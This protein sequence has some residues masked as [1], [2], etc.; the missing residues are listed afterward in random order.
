MSSITSGEKT[1]WAAAF[2]AAYAEH[3]SIDYALGIAYKAVLDIRSVLGATGRSGMTETQ[4]AIYN[5][6]REATE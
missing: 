6:A 2:V 3:S 4:A 1:V 5:M